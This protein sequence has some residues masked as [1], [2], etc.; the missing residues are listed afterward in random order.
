MELADCLLS[1]LS[2]PAP[3][4]SVSIFILKSHFRTAKSD[5][6]GQL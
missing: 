1:G 5:F 4:G 6:N 3:L 2:T